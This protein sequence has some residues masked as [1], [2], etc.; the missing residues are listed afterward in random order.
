MAVF[1]GL[2]PTQ[3]LKQF[4]RLVV[5]Y[6]STVY[7][8]K[9]QFS[10]N[11]QFKYFNSDR[12]FLVGLVSATVLL[13]G[14]SITYEYVYDDYPAI[15]QNPHLRQHYKKFIKNLSS[16]DFWGK[17]LNSTASHGSWRPITTGCDLSN[18]I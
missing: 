17:S 7:D 16:R 10:M 14:K 8:L 13:F 5:E 11:G 1:F 3:I 4:G 18:G 6:I 15:V 12:I 9:G 2:V